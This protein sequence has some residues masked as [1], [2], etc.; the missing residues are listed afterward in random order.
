ML[1]WDLKIMLLPSITTTTLKKK[2]F[3]QHKRSNLRRSGPDKGH[4]GG[5]SHKQKDSKATFPNL[6]QAY[7]VGFQSLFTPCTTT[8]KFRP[9]LILLQCEIYLPPITTSALELESFH[10]QSSFIFSLLSDFL[11]KHGQSPPCTSY[12]IS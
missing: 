11:L 12:F 7:T 4:Q 10:F 9:L 2:K 1:A 3:I 8:S 6:P 5:S